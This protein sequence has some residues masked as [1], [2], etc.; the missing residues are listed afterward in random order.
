MPSF[1]VEDGTGLSNATSYTD[2]AT[3]DDLL[4]IE[5]YLGSAW[6]A[7]TTND[8]ETWAMWT[9]KFM[10]TTIKYA[11]YKKSQ[12]QSLE[13]PRTLVYNCDG[14]LVSDEEVPQVIKELQSKLCGYY[15][16]NTTIN[17][18]SPLSDQLDIT[19]IK[20]AEIGVTFNRG[21]GAVYPSEVNKYPSFINAILDC[22]GTGKFPTSG[23]GGF[24]RIC[25]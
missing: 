13:W 20:L 21:K 9:T 14:F 4:S 24:K 11:G 19:K 5:V 2:I 12:T 25:G 17:P 10:D 22:Y 16:L 1:V 3:I 15:T 23:M 8:K 18:Y 6:N 7:L